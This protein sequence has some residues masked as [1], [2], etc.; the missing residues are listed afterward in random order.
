[1]FIL[2]P[3]VTAGVA[4]YLIDVWDEPGRWFHSGKFWP[5]LLPGG[6]VMALFA[7]LT[8]FIVG[9]GLLF[10]F[11]VLR[12]STLHRLWTSHAV[13]VLAR[14]SVTAII[15]FGAL[16]LARDLESMVAA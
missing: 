6:L 9:P 8:I 11:L 2:L 7:P 1:M 13:T 10:A 3:A 5:T 16:D 4:A 14:L 12:G 15:A